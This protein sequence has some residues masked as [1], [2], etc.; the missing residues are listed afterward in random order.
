[1]RASALSDDQ[2][3]KTVNEFFVPVEINVTVNGFPKQLPA[4]R[5]VEG[6]YNSNWR[7]EFGFASCL[8]LDSEGNII[9]GTSITSALSE[10]KERPDPELLFSPRK[11]MEFIVVSLERFRKLQNI[12]KMPLLQKLNGWKEFLTDITSDIQNQVQTMAKF[13]TFLQ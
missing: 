12:Q 2:V 10:I 3:I 7:N 8:I 11:Y 4:M 13:R 1:M 5:I 9:L 6:I